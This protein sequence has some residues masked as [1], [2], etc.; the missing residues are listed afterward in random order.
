MLV[1]LSPVNRLS[2]IVAPDRLRKVMIRFRSRREL[3]QLRALGNEP[4]HGRI[5]IGA[6]RRV[7][8]SS[9]EDSPSDV[10][11]AL[12]LDAPRVWSKVRK[13][14]ACRGEL[15]ALCADSVGEVDGAGVVVGIRRAY[16]HAH[17]RLDRLA[18]VVGV[19]VAHAIEHERRRAALDVLGSAVEVEDLVGVGPGFRVAVAV[20]S[21]A[22]DVVLV[23]VRIDLQELALDQDARVSVALDDVHHE[24]ETVRRRKRR[25]SDFGIWSGDGQGRETGDEREA[26]L[27]SFVFALVVTG[28]DP[29]VSDTMDTGDVDVSWHP[30]YTCR[31]VRFI[32]SG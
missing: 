1:V 8:R 27:L 3:I 16:E 11:L 2:I 29:I 24:P 6:R 30:I 19:G 26:H 18:V 13:G 31:G 4:N 5:L 15:D 17:G 20:D 12:K 9:L 14:I 25:G 23:P 32:P 28:Y 22:L 7:Q 10:R 21:Q